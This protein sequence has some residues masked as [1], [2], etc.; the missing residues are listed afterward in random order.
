K[1]YGDYDLVL[2]AQDQVGN[3]VTTTASL[4]LDGYGPY[5]DLV[6]ST[7]FITSSTS[8]LSGTVGDILHQPQSSRLHLHFE[9]AAGATEFGDGSGNHFA[10]TCSGAACPTAGQSGQH[11]SALRFDGLDD[12]LTVYGTTALSVTEHLGLYDDSFTVMAWLNADDL[13]GDRAVLG[14]GTNAANQ[15]LFVGLRNGKPHLGFTGDDT[16]GITTTLST[17]QWTHLAWRYDLGS[18]EHALFIDGELELA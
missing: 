14:A 17:G 9:E 18:G 3:P 15:G 6:I 12:G 10:A 11:G 1:P 16:T 2:N 8:V 13:S 4:Q 7:Y 5:A